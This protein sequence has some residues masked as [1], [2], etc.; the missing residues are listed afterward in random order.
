MPNYRFDLVQG[1]DDWLAARLGIPTA[2][3]FDK[4]ITAKKLALSESCRPYLCK[5]IAEWLYG[6]PLD[7]YDV[8]AHGWGLR[9]KE[10]EP[11]A[12]RYYEMEKGIDTQAIGFVTTDDGT[13]GASPDRLVGQ[14]G[15]YEG[16]APGLVAHVGY[17]LEPQTLLDE[18]RIQHQGQLWICHDRDWVDMQSYHPGFPSV[19]VRSYRDEKVQAALS[20]HIPAFVATMLSARIKLTQAY[21][22]LRRERVTAQQRDEASRAAFDEFMESKIG[23]V[24]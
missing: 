19:I 24:V 10:L 12:V 9:G 1:S 7:G 3:E 11:E 20:M 13:A 5:L 21:G 4:I 8:G 17:M 14:V 6:A 22:E 16:K 15:L 23:G 18:Y 2:S